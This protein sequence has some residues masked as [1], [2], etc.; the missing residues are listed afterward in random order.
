MYVKVIVTPG[1]K[2]EQCV[3][4]D[5]TSFQISVRQEA[6]QNRA[7]VRVRE[8]I[9]THFGQPVGSVRIVTGHRSPRKIMYIE[10]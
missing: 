7:N 9:A 2:K 10:K 4:T 6:R 1:A 3:Q 8:L 5:E